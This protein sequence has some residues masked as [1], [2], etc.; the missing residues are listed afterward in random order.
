MGLL[1]LGGIGASLWLAV[2]PL[3]DQ[4]REL[5]E[6]WP[7]LWNGLRDRLEELEVEEKRFAI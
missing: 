3:M 1:I 6:Q 4:G 2:P 7:R 5:V